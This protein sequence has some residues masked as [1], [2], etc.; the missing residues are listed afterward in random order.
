MAT[1]IEKWDA[2]IAPNLHKIEYNSMWA[3]YHAT[4]V[5]NSCEA[6]PSIPKW[7]T[8][9]HDELLRA[10]ASIEETLATLKEAEK[11][12]TSKPIGE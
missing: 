3:K 11:K 9:A 12:L 2:E 5:L 6:V 1:T 4:A 7:G 10:I 8:R